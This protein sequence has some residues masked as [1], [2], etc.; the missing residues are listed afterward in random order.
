M[1]VK[2]WVPQV[3]ELKQYL[4][5]FHRVHNEEETKLDEAEIVDILEYGVPN[6]YWR[7]FTVQGFNPFV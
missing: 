1:M 7:D 5:E 4:K 2:E 6:F 3:I